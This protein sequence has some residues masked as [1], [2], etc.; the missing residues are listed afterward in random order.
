MRHTALARHLRREQTASE[1]RLWTLVRGRRLADAKFRRQVPI[2]RYVADFV[3]VEA[4][5]IVEIDGRVH[6]DEEAQLRDIERTT[7]LE[8]CGYLLIRF[9]NDL[10]LNAPGQVCD[11]IVAT[12]RAARL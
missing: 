8:S 5:L 2:D 11:V 3:C 7:V 6:D 1:A 9:S 10:V 12:L 4:R